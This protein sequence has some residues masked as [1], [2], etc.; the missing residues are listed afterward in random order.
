VH[1]IGKDWFVLSLPSPAEWLPS[2]LTEAER[3]VAAL[4][5][6]GLSNRAIAQ[7][8]K[9]SVRTVANQIASVFRKLKVAGRTELAGVVLGRKR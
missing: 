6:E 9:T 2:E 4:V 8:R 5:L 7:H 1:A 3:D